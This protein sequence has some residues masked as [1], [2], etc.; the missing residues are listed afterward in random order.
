MIWRPPRSTRT[1]TLFPDPTL[2]RSRRRQLVARRPLGRGVLGRDVRR[3]R[4]VADRRRRSRLS[5]LHGAQPH[6]RRRSRDFRR[7]RRSRCRPVAILSANRPRFR[8]RDR[9]VLLAQR[10]A[11][12]RGRPAPLLLRPACYPPLIVCCSTFPF[13]LPPP[14]IL[15]LSFFLFLSL[16]FLFFPF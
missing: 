5:Q 3:P 15:S 8:H 12:G 1:D 13:C 14:S 7:S 10:P 11:V 16:P 9:P 2:F 4:G 6:P